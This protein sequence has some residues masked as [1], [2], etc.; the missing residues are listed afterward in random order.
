M[1]QPVFI[2]FP[3]V[4]RFYNFLIVAIVVACTG[5][6]FFD[7]HQFAKSDWVRLIFVYIFFDHTHTVLTPYLLATTPEGR[8]Y[9][10]DNFRRKSTFV[11]GLF[12]LIAI[13][14]MYKFMK[15][16]HPLVF[17]PA[18]EVFGFLLFIL[19]AQHAFKQTYGLSLLYNRLVSQ[20]LSREAAV[21]LSRYEII[22]KR[23][24]QIYVSLG[25][26]ERSF[27]YMHWSRSIE[28]LF[29]ALIFITVCAIYVLISRYPGG[30]IWN[31]KKI[32]LARLWLL[33]L[34]FFSPLGAIALAIV[35]GMDYALIGMRM[36][37][38]S[39]SNF[40][41][42]ITAL[43]PV[44]GWVFV[45]PSFI[46]NDGAAASRIFGSFSVW[47]DWLI[48]TLSGFAFL[49][50]YSHYLTDGFIFRLGSKDSR[51]NFGPLLGLGQLSKSEHNRK[52]LET[53]L[54]K[55]I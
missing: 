42:R 21:E 4:E 6:I 43:L 24:F 23:L 52:L 5:S 40:R 41:G 46:I 30:P 38:R 26:A 34:A 1:P 45:I 27:S 28:P 18:V 10:V 14:I 54:P 33:P 16:Y 49:L 13:L 25:V 55:A 11:K 51:E 39:K 32:Y 2:F 29:V 15:N 44:L 8:S 3:R 35:H 9:I 36:T 31:T 50:G 37:S 47:P 22:E 48:L 20:Q 12:A 53:K 19:W 7:T 17:R